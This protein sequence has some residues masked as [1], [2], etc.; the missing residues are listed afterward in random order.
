MPGNP[1]VQLGTLNRALVAIQLISLP[2]LNVTRGFFGD[3]LA[4]LTFEGATA[5]YIPA[6]TGAVPSGRLFQV[7]TVLAYLL[8]SQSLAN[9][10]EQQRLTI[11]NIGDVNVVTDSPTL[12][13]YY[14]QNCIL[15]NVADIEMTGLSTDFPVQIKGT[16]L[17]N[18]NLY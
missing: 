5:D 17:I 2:Q 1:Q 4:R 7:C 16:Y 11:S 14:L 15:E 9:L 6:Q 3:K 13:P 18:G 8:K 12:Q 10:W